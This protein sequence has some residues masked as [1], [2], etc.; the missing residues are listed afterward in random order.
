MKNV[1]LIILML[2]LTSMAYSAE[3]A[4]R[5]GYGA[6][7]A[8]EDFFNKLSD[9]GLNYYIWKMGASPVTG[10]KLSWEDGRLKVV[11]NQKVINK[12]KLAAKNAQKHGVKLLL[13]VGFNKQTLKA[14][15]SLG[16][17]D[18]AVVDGPRSYLSRGI[19]NAPWPGDKKLWNGIML[20]DALIAAKL[21][22]ENPGIG[23]F[24]F[25]LEMYAGKIN[26]WYCASFDAKV[27]NIST[28]NI[29][30]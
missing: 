10:G 15:R 18:K 5:C 30:I 21:A 4:I 11:P 14:L 17:Y 3:E 28:K 2:F 8:K 12:I 25:D 16:P 22:K 7:I 6:G 13:S 20:E 19:N 23:G 26:W 29:L 27:W 24:L 1:Y 9:A